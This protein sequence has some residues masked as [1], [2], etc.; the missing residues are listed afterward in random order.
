M[1]KKERNQARNMGWFHPKWQNTTFAP[2]FMVYV[3]L[4]VPFTIKTPANT[5]SLL[6]LTMIDPAIKHR[7]VHNCHIHSPTYF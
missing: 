5:H 4:V 6:A 3:D 2:W 7:L 1:A